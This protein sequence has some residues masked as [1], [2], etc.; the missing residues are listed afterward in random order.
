MFEDSV[1]A[2]GLDRTEFMNDPGMRRLLGRRMGCF[3]CQFSGTM[4]RLEFTYEL[5]LGTKMYSYE[6]VLASL[7]DPTHF[8]TGRDGE[9]AARTY[10]VPI[11][12]LLFSMIG[13]FTHIFKLSFTA[14]EYVNLRTFAKV[15]AA[16]SP[17]SNHVIDNT[18]RVLLALMAGMMIFIYFSENR[19]TGPAP[20][21]ALHETMWKQ[22]PIVGGIATH[23][24]INAQALIYPF[25]RQF[26]PDWLAFNDDPFDHFP[27]SLFKN[28]VRGDDW[29]D[30]G[31]D[32]PA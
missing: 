2:P 14:A 21:K 13:A 16:D 27:L 18:R 3:D 32:A 1:I 23:W 20:Y 15:N 5:F 19:V 6:S 30:E 9:T 29:V 31:E 28:W 12:A 7:E 4:D 11:W 10:W 25:T 24:T 22:N 17:L 26:T 8:E